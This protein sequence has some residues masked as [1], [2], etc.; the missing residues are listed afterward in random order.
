M[1]ANNAFENGR[2]DKRRAAQQDVTQVRHNACKV[3]W[4]WKRSVVSNPLANFLDSRASS[5]TQSQVA[6]SKRSV[7]T[8]RTMWGRYMG[9]GG[10]Y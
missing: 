4:S 7:L 1:T 2:A 5:A 10:S 3:N 9:A 8:R 6:N